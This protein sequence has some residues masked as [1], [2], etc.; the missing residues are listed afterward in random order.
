MAQ[1]GL[2]RV[3][4]EV[5]WTRRGAAGAATAGEEPWMRKRAWSLFVTELNGHGRRRQEGVGSH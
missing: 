2:T 5:L 3:P 1:S 4:Q